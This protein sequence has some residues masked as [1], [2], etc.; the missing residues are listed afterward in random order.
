[1][2]A[3]DELKFTSTESFQLFTEGLRSLQA[4]GREANYSALERAAARLEECTRKFP[5]DVLPKFYLGVVKTELG[6]RGLDDAISVFHSILETKAEQLKPA[7]EY[8]LAV[9]L[10]RRYTPGDLENAKRILEQLHDRLGPQWSVDDVA[11]RLQIEALQN[12]LFVRQELWFKRYK[13][14]YRK[15]QVEEAR[16]RLDGFKKDIEG[17]RIP[18]AKKSDILATHWNTEGLVSE[19]LAH[20]ADESK[21][22]QEQGRRA[23]ANFE[24]ALALKANWIPALSNLARIYQDILEQSGKA[25]GTWRQ[26]LEIRPDDEYS[27][28]MLGNLY[29]EDN[30]LRAINCYARAPKIPEA[31]FK[32][33]QAY[34]QTGQLDKAIEQ[35]KKA[36]ESNEHAS[37]RLGEIFEQD[38]NLPLALEWYKKA[39]K[40]PKAQE[41]V[42]RLE[43]E[44]SPPH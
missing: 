40:L 44:Y 30:P 27:F 8:N 14:E 13:P 35:Y 17:V 3:S 1:M 9:A 20:K 33:G 18:E 12:F 11:L 5:A 34:E 23:V 29:S 2:P 28:Y 25:E 24:Q 10:M 42:K 22:K 32:M 21:A 19:Y 39:P 36:S 4:Y 43:S 26:V 41:A 37:L 7:A 15:D 16:R 6:Y 31:G 38:G